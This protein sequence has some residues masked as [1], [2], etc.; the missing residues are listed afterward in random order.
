VSYSQRYLFHANPDTKAVF[1]LAHM[2]GVHVRRTCT[3]Y[4]YDS[5][6][7]I[8]HVRRTCTPYMLV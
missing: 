7:N 8:A 4:M 2:Y 3:P 6:K 5:V 1:T